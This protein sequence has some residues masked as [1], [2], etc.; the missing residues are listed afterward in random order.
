ME[1][2]RAIRCGSVDR[3]QGTE[4]KSISVD[5]DATVPVF[6]VHLPRVRARTCDGG[7]FKG[8]VTPVNSGGCNG[9]WDRRTPPVTMARLEFKV[10]GWCIDARELGELVFVATFGI[11]RLL[12]PPKRITGLPVPIA[13][14]VIVIIR[15]WSDATPHRALWTIH[16]SRNRVFLSCVFSS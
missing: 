14:L 9:A 7:Q 11:T 4:T 3:A 6:S 12:T 2:Q 13:R 8:L 5:F 15:Y 16:R 10:H 1:F